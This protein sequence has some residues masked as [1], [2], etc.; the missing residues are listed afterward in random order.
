MSFQINDKMCSLVLIIPMMSFLRC[1]YLL[2]HHLERLHTGIVYLEEI[3][4]FVLKSRKLV[5]SNS[6]GVFKKVACVYRKISDR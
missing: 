6:F 5:V 3:M 4:I 1:V 2:V